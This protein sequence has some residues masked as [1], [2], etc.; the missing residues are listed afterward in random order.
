L[1]E[2]FNRYVFWGEKGFLILLN[3]F[4]LPQGSHKNWNKLKIFEKI[5]I[6]F[7]PINKVNSSIIFRDSKRDLKERS[8]T[9]LFLNKNEGNFGI[10]P[11]GSHKNRKIPGKLKKIKFISLR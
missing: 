11:Q 3:F 4:I 1:K 2:L 8:N 6:S 5:Q 9:L 10:A 7:Y